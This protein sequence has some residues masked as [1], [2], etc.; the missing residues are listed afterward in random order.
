MLPVDDTDNGDLRESGSSRRN[1]KRSLLKRRL[2]MGTFEPGY[3][4]LHKSGEL[5]KRVEAT[6]NI[7]ADCTLCPWH[8][9]VNRLE[10]LRRLD[11]I[12]A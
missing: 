1:R 12:T 10:G 9:H 5:A 6:R 2:V 3:I 11:G 8:C 4:G 7:L